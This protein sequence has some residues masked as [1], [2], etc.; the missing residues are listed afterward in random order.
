MGSWRLDSVSS[1]PYRAPLQGRMP[2]EKSCR[3]GGMLVFRRSGFWSERVFLKM[4]LS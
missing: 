2:D 3:V 1:E 4:E